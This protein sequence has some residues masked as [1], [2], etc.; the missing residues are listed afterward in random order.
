MTAPE[1]EHKEIEFSIVT[2]T[3]G[4]LTKRFSVKNGEL[5]KDSS[6]CLLQHGKV[7]RISATFPEIPAILDNLKENQA[8]IHGTVDHDE[9]EVV[10]KGLKPNYPDAITRTK[11]IFTYPPCGLL[12]FDYDALANGDSLSKAELI[13]ALRSLDPQLQKAAMIWRPSA[14]SCITDGEDINIGIQNQRIYMPYEGTSDDLKDFVEG[15]NIAAWNKGFGHIFISVAG[16]AFPRGLF[17]MAVFSPE[18]LDFSAGAVCDE[19]LTQSLPPTEY[20][21]GDFVDLSDFPEGDVLKQKSQI[22]G[23]MAAVQDDIDRVRKNYLNSQAEKLADTQG[24]TKKKAKNIVEARMQLKLLPKDI[25]Y[26]DNNEE[27]QIM[28]ILDDPDK[29]NGMVI[30]DPLEPDYGPSKAKIYADEEGVRVNSFA[31]GGRIFF[32]NYDRDY[33]LLWLEKNDE[34][35]VEGEWSEKIKSFHGSK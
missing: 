5:K 12:D 11:D 29:Y 4:I 18:R 17:D 22:E 6:E 34:G 30:R 28:D 26:T 8:V 15:L 13:D 31:H 23:A 35:E 16:T 14:S 19:P 9:V 24:L 21:P 27:I 3:K 10:S 32:V 20:T 33:L 25:L 2:K 7:E 1:S